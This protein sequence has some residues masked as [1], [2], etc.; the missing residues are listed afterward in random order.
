[1]SVTL[2][3]DGDPLVY[4]CG[5]VAERRRHIL[6]WVDVT[7]DG[8]VY[9]EA[10]FE[11]AWRRDAFIDLMN[12]HPD[13]WACQTYAIPYDFGFAVQ[14]LRTTLAGIED[15]VRPYLIHLGLE[16]GPTQI[17]LTGGD[18][19]RHNVA[20][21]RPYK[22]NRGNARP[23]WYAKLREY[24]VERHGA[25]VVDEY[26]ADDAIAMVQ[27]QTA[28]TV[29]PTSIIC[30]I[31]KDLKMVPGLHYHT[32]DK[33]AWYQSPQGALECFYRQLLTGDATD[34]IPGLYR[35]G[36]SRAAVLLPSGLSE[37][38]MYERVLAE[39]ATNMAKYPEH[40]LPHTDPAEC[41]AENARLLWM[42]RHPD[43]K[44][45]PPGR[46]R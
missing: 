32:K 34:N 29:E 12:L 35:V 39:Y 37:R 9:H 36:K 22:G 24:M 23:F 46:P 17:Y 18:N 14:A 38:D 41:L 8:D 2:L 26:E 4:S 5:Y 21:I 25:I 44:W 7:T 42:L 43:D 30:T 10:E 3:I 15:N 31:D 13:E 16:P 45:Y 27:W 40:H 33:E 19:F 6:S 28:Y 11:H 1:M 20:T